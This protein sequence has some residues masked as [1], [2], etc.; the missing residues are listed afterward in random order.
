MTSPQRGGI[1]LLVVRRMAHRTPRWA[2]PVSS[3]A[4]PCQ[5]PLAR[6]GGRAPREPCLERAKGWQSHEVRWSGHFGDS[7][8]SAAPYH[9][10]PHRPWS[11]R[12]FLCKSAIPL[13]LRRRST[14]GVA[15]VVIMS[16]W[17]RALPHAGSLPVRRRGQ[18]DAAPQR[19]RQWVWPPLCG[20]QATAE[21]TLDSCATPSARLRC[22][23]RMHGWPPHT[24]HGRGGVGA[25]TCGRR[26]ARGM[27][28]LMSTRSTPRA[29][30]QWRRFV[31]HSTLVRLNCGALSLRL[32][33]CAWHEGRRPDRGS[34]HR[35]GLPTW[36]CMRRGA[37]LRAGSMRGWSV[38]PYGA[39]SCSL[40]FS[41]STSRGTSLGV[42]TSRCAG[43]NPSRCPRC[44]AARRAKVPTRHPG[45]WQLLRW[46]RAR[47][48]LHRLCDRWRFFAR[49]ISGRLLGLGLR[50]LGQGHAFPVHVRE[51]GRGHCPV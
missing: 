41:S 15:G 49:S 47:R 40:S 29:C 16:L 18:S 51:A 7:R 27:S 17:M 31:G 1:V 39:T 34:H 4:A 23:R 21:Y 33:P 24:P 2:I 12:A 35:V 28:L 43:P 9:P 37:L 26:G 14:S 10:Q 30:Y 5:V 44:S 48:P 50:G 38:L 20:M 36:L 6:L 11:P 45:R 46:N 32:P 19:G 25:W 3:M 13:A 8:R 22:C 42:L